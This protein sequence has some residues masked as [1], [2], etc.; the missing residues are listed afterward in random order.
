VLV[1]CLAQA[2][3]HELNASMGAKLGRKLDFKKAFVLYLAKYAGRF[4][5]NTMTPAEQQRIAGVGA[6]HEGYVFEGPRIEKVRQLIGE[7]PTG[8]KILDIGCGNGTVLACHANKHEIHGVEINEEL[9]TRA[10]K[11]GM[12]AVVHDVESGPMPYPDKTFD[13]VFCGETIEHQV[14]TDWLMAEI[15]RV[16]KPGGTLVLTYPN[17]RTA[18]GIGMLLIFDLPPMYAARYRAPH[19]RDFTLKTIKMVLN[20]NGFSFS[21]ALGSAFYLPVIGEYWSWL[22]TYFPSWAHTVVVCAT[23]SKDSVYSAE[24]AKPGA[25]YG[26]WRR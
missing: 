24:D 3:F 26:G 20:N 12:K 10:N 2:L 18:L 23:K 5:Q 8:R 13:V 19:Y 22:A 21:K 9:V 17:V 14:D 15:N 4:A 6:Y 16:L 1:F 7:M 25:L 11:I